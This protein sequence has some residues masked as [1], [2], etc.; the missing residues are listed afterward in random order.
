MAYVYSFN[1]RF[2]THEDSLT[3]RI[4]KQWISVFDMSNAQYNT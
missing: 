2:Y 3:M 1:M 4:G